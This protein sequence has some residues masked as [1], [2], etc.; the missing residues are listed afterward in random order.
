MKFAE[1][2]F[3]VFILIG[4]VLRLFNQQSALFI[5]LGFAGLALLYLLLG[6]FLFNGIRLRSIFRKTS[7]T[8]IP[9]WAWPVAL[10]GACALAMGLIG[11]LCTALQY[12]GHAFALGF[13]I[14]FCLFTDL[15]FF[16][17]I[18]RT[19]LFHNLSQ[20][21]LMVFAGSI[22]ALIVTLL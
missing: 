17:T 8:G 14:T 22:V 7:Y 1:K 3:V 11:L 18:R 16:F 13:G 21:I 5:F 19:L 9:W 4:F 10:W 2:I 6:P 20:R 12:R 15:I